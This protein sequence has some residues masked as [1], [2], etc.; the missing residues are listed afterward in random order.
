MII[1]T[2]SPIDLE[3]F[4]LNMPEPLMECGFER[5]YSCIFLDLAL[6]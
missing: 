4:M 3:E 1:Y 6:P 2:H 5:I